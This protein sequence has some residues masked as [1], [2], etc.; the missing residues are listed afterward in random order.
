[1]KCQFKGDYPNSLCVEEIWEDSNY[2]VLHTDF[3]SDKTSES[4]SKLFHEKAKKFNEKVNNEDFHFAGAILFEVNLSGYNINDNIFFEEAKILSDVNFIGANVNGNVFFNSSKILGSVF[5]DSEQ[6]KKTKIEG[7]L[8]FQGADINDRAFFRDIEVS[9]DIKFHSTKIGSVCRFNNAKI[10]GEFWL[11]DS[12]IGNFMDFRN[13]HIGRLINY[14]STIE[15]F[16]FF[17]NTKFERNVSFKKSIF[18]NEVYFEQA[19]FLDD[20]IFEDVEFHKNVSFSNSRFLGNRGRFKR[21]ENF[22]ANFESAKLDNVYFRQCDLTQVRFKDVIFDNCELSTSKLPE[23]IIEHKE[24]EK[25]KI[26]INNAKIFPKRITHITDSVTLIEYANDVADIYRRIRQCLEN[27][28]A[29][30]E[31]GEFY[32]K[33][34]DFR[35]T[36][37]YKKVNKSI[38]FTYTFL[39][40]TSKYGENSKILVFLIILYYFIIGATVNIFN[41]NPTNPNFMY[42]NL[43][44]IPIG[45]FLIALFVYSFAR[46]MSR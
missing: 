10:I 15:R 40:I 26:I 8:N 16:A 18:K 22:K 35:R 17:D 29:Y 31:S 1:M 19:I 14:G 45:S 39:N 5:F 46:K 34:M 25:S 30:M 21:L 28:G 38:Y 32:K 36:E 12:T 9:K 3:P 6:Y 23:K 37:V 11:I 44:I 13:A 2:C 42:Y 27:Q 7:S 24:Y 33:E 20:T 4:Y 43:A 41:I